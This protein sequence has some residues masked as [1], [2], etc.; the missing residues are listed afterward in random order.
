MGS[1]SGDCAAL[2]GTGTDVDGV[3]WHKVGYKGTILLRRKRIACVATYH[4][5]VLRPIDKGIACIGFGRDRNKFAS[6]I[7]SSTTNRTACYGVCTDVD[8]VEWYEVGHKGIV[9]VRHKRIVCVVAHHIAILRPIEKGIARISCCNNANRFILLIT[10]SAAHR[11]TCCGAGT[12]VDG[13]S[14]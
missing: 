5:A 7:G 12:D 13:I 4:S 9:L 14:S 6:L 2:C 3:E 8:G 1:T 10:F 11:A